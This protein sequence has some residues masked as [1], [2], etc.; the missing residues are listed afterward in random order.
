[1][2]EATAIEVAVG[3]CVI[4]VIVN[5]GELETPILIKI[6]PMEVLVCTENLHR[7]KMEDS[8]R[9]LLVE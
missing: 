8:I 1:V 7:Q 2:P 4:L 3:M 9:G 5:L 6:F